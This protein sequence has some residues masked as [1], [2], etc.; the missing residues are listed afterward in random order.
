MHSQVSSPC[1]TEGPAPP[2]GRT[3]VQGIHAEGIF[4]L[5]SHDT[6]NCGRWTHVQVRQILDR[7]PAGS[8]GPPLPAAWSVEERDAC[9]I[10]RE[11]GGQGLAFVYF[12]EEPGRR[13]A[14]SS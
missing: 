5:L 11:N 7:E 14:A 9:F 13:A 4:L 1:P 8:D 2:L 6:A 12:E 10:V 3:L